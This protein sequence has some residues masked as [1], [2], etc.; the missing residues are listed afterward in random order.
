MIAYLIGNIQLNIHLHITVCGEK[1]PKAM[2]IVMVMEGNT[3]IERLLNKNNFLQSREDYSD[4]S[5][6]PFKIVTELI[7]RFI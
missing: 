3:K 5:P 1:P 2:V 7:K 4:E 6:I